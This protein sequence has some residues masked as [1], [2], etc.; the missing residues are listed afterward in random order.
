MMAS[1]KNIVGTYRKGSNG[2]VISFTHKNMM[3]GDQA[4]SEERIKYRKV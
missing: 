1:T 2:E 3:T 4:K